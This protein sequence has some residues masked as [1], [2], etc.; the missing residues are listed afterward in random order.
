MANFSEVGT[1]E[2]SCTELE[3]EH[4]NIQNSCNVSDLRILC[5]FVVIANQGTRNEFKH[6]FHCCLKKDEK[7]G[8]RLS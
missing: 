4:Q 7:C 1:D 5:L 3:N 2:I 8:L 6:A